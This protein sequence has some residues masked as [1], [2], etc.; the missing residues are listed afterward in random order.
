MAVIDLVVVKKDGKFFPGKV[1][2]GKLV[3]YKQIKSLKS[4]RYRDEYITLEA[5]LKITDTKTKP[6]AIL[7]GFRVDKLY[8]RHK[9]EVST[10]KTVEIQEVKVDSV[11]GIRQE[12]AWEKQW[13]KK[14]HP[15]CI[16]CKKSCKQSHMVLFVGCPTRTTK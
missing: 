6:Q 5:W 12:K 11:G 10:S 15:T 3:K 16:P 4:L 8:V 7:A 14:F 13:W 1:K 9:T 2:N